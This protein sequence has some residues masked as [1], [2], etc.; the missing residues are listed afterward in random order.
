MFQELLRNAAL[1]TRIT[2]ALPTE[3]K[4]DLGLP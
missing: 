3:A 2:E 4:A 1:R